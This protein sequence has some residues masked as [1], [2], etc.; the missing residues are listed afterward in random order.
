MISKE[1]LVSNT[2]IDFPD[3]EE[4]TNNVRNNTLAASF[5]PMYGHKYVDSQFTDGF[6]G[7]FGFFMFI[8][9]LVPVSRLISRV[10]SEKETKIRESMKMMG[11]TDAPWWLSWIIMYQIIYT[12]SAIANTFL[13]WIIF[14]YSNKFIV[15]LMFFLYGTSCTAFSMIFGALFSKSKTAI[16]VGVLVFFTS[17]FTIFSITDNTT[18]G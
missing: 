3:D 14:E 7:F 8:T 4:F 6:S 10:S 17:Y 16:L 1:D 5:V 18:N 9:S 15:F 12:F 11:L 2:L 13:S